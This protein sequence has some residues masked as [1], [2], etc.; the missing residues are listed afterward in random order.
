MNVYLGRCHGGDVEFLVDDVG[1]LWDV[2][3]L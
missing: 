2:V 1:I 3:L